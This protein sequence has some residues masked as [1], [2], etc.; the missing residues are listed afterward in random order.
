MIDEKLKAPVKKFRV[1]TELAPKFSMT[2]A[3]YL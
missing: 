2:K 1:K 3:S